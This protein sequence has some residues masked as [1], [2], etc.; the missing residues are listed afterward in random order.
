MVHCAPSNPITHT[1]TAFLISWN[2][3]TQSR[4]RGW[5]IV[6]ELCGSERGHNIYETRR[7]VIK[8]SYREKGLISF[9]A[10]ECVCAVLTADGELLL[11]PLPFLL[12]MQHPLTPHC[13][14]QDDFHTSPWD[15]PEYCFLWI[16]RETLSTIVFIFILQH[17]VYWSDQKIDHTYTITNV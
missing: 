6:R 9:L 15:L 5:W 8:L 12:L 3:P 16:E 4:A 2:T 13:T 11:F 17:F 1:P 14:T 10:C 7:E